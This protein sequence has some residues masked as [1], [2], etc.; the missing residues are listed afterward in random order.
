VIKPEVLHQ[1][2]IKDNSLCIANK[3]ISQIL[4][5]H[6]GTEFDNPTYLYAKDIIRS[7][8]SELRSVL[9]NELDIFYS[10]KANP[11]QELINFL[12]PLVDGYDVSSLKE[13]HLALNTG[14]EPSK[15]CYTGPGKSN[16]E[17]EAAIANHVVISAESFLELQ[18][19]DTLS[20][21]TADNAAILI[22]I[23]PD[24]VQQ[25]AG[26][27]MASGPSPFGID[28]EQLPEIIQWVENSSIDLQGFHVY[29][30]SQILDADAI[31][32]TQIKTLELL[33]KTA[34]LCKKPITTFNIGGGFGIPYFEKHTPLDLNSVGNN[35]TNLLEDLHNNKNSNKIQPI[36]ELGRY[37]V[38]AAGLYLCKV[39]DK[40]VSKGT[41]YL[42]TNGGMQ[43]HLA[44]SGNLGQKNRK[45]FPVIVANKI[46]SKDV[47][48]VTIVGKLCTPLDIIAEQ[49]TLSKCEIGDTIAVLQSGA[50]GLSA[51]PINFL[52]HPT[53][54]EILI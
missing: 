51:S 49:V 34:S 52:G 44:A 20:K 8:V 32:N 23:N 10:V 2:E 25:R 9:P 40:K 31:N 26:M 43:H 16:E 3:T 7:K 29:C 4:T 18:R 21:N 27:K 46:A 39:T 13:L 17:L 30:G 19:I 37:I 6:L 1:F 38:G 22:R 41:T 28:A 33:Q 45:N 35:L 36:I 50:Y 53:A 47:E 15:I 42:I 48:Q 24:F 12:R 14:I 11:F 5:E 54:T